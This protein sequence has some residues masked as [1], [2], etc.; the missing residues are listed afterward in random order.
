MYYL[1][2]PRCT[3]SGFCTGEE[4]DVFT[5]MTVVRMALPSQRAVKLL[6][7]N[8]CTRGGHAT[9]PEM[10]I[11]KHHGHINCNIHKHSGHIKYNTD[12]AEGSAQVWRV[13]GGTAPH[14]ATNGRDDGE[15]HVAG[16]RSCETHA[17]NL[18][19]SRCWSR[20]VGA[21]VVVGAVGW[22]CVPVEASPPIDAYAVCSPDWTCPEGL[23]H[24]CGEHKRHQHHHRHRHRH[25]HGGHE[26]APARWAEAQG[27][28]EGGRREGP[29]RC[30]ARPRTAHAA[31][32]LTAG[33]VCGR[34]ESPTA[35]RS[36]GLKGQ[37]LKWTCAGR[38][39]VQKR[40]K[41]WG[42]AGGATVGRRV[43]GRARGGGRAW[44]QE[45]A[46]AW[47]RASRAPLG[48][49]ETPPS[50]AARPARRSSGPHSP[51]ARSRRPAPIAIV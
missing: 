44:V 5:P 33:W 6:G 34:A 49:E 8:R 43:G 18:V 21:S 25:R 17:V 39:W 16:S 11:E 13:G 41:A 4:S 47:V 19:T 9:R 3:Q 37:R 14:N 40:A 30:D 35:P 48:G 45:R 15:R 23:Q 51:S 31:A 36:Q 38:T 28:Q 24:S 20:W 1:Q 7:W 29:R 26:C 46:K 22:V 12:G 32:R 42:C 50:C 10:A 27:E 2:R